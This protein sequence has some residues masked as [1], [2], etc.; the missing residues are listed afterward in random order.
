MTPFMNGRFDLIPGVQMDDKEQRLDAI[1]QAFSQSWLE[2]KH[3]NPLQRLWARKDVLASY[4]LLSFGDA[5]LRLKPSF[6]TFIKQQVHQAKS[7]DHS[8]RSGAYFEILALGAML[9]EAQTIT[10]APKNNP[11]FDVT[12][13]RD[14]RST[15]VSLK[16]HSR[17]SRETK[18]I[19]ESKRLKAVMLDRA[20]ALNIMDLG[21]S[22]IAQR[23]PSAAD[24]T[25]LIKAAP[26]IVTEF[27]GG[28][29]VIKN[30]GAAWMVGIRPIESHYG[31]LSPQHRSYEMLVVAP[32]YENEQKNLISN[33]E[34]A[35]GNFVKHAAK[36]TA[37][38]SSAILLRLPLSASV[39][40]CADWVRDYFADR[41]DAPIDLVN[42]YKPDI[43]R[44]S[45]T[46]TITH[47]VTAITRP[48]TNPAPF[49]MSFY[50]GNVVANPVRQEFHVDDTVIP[51]DD[52]YVYQDGEVYELAT[53]TSS[54]SAAN[55]SNPVA[56]IRKM[57]VF[58]IGGQLGVIGG[59][60]A[61]ADLFE[62]LA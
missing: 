11:G 1:V 8:E 52:R 37:A 35:C 27:A 50:I 29:R 49:R 4:E 56:G 23:F 32:H 57:A 31:Q 28:T 60:W 6:G 40:L 12:V 10:P 55:V 25:E 26:G 34:T 17:S 24:W 14:G 44:T 3:D 62:L 13:T 43:T 46:T 33:I 54:G 19:Y 20:A 42:L 48:R 22:V 15:D 38:A 36:R 58:N 41:P 7:N 16:S 5:I 30:V 39:P 47:Q 45:D 18:F 51:A 2:G 59:K 53:Q 9:N 21:I 61:E